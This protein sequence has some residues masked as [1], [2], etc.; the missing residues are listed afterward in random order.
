MIETK[1][2][3]TE[4]RTETG[5]GTEIRARKRTVRNPRTGPRN[6]RIRC[7]LDLRE[8]LVHSS[9][10][11][12]SCTSRAV[13]K[14]DGV[15]KRSFMA[16]ECWP[17]SFQGAEAVKTLTLPVEIYGGYRSHATQC[18]S[19]PFIWRDLVPDRRV[20]HPAKLPRA[21]HLSRHFLLKL[22][23]LLTRE[24][25]VVSGGSP[26]IDGRVILLAGLTF[27]HVNTLAHPAGSTWLRRDNQSMPE[28]CW[29]G[30]GGQLFS[31]IN[32]AKVGLAGRLTLF[33]GTTFL[34]INGALACVQSSPIIEGT[35]R[36]LCV[37][38]GFL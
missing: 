32:A 30:Q 10:F 4:R 16:M 14:E 27:L 3:T 9:C 13:E 8:D 29:P 37:V 12:R 24:T 28:C 25:K 15:R 23:E 17:A 21:S 22:G 38:Y 19:S 36:C 7:W 26:F 5:I 18:T 6:L 33:P 1:K 2:G 20:P 34:Y 31:H 35:M 11:Y